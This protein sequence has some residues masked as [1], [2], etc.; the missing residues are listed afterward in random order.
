MLLPGLFALSTEKEDA[1]ARHFVQE[2]G[3]KYKI[4]E[5][6]D[7]VAALAQSL[8]AQRSIDVKTIES[9]QPLANN[10]PAG[11]VYISTALVQSATTAELAAILAHQIVHAT[12]RHG[13]I[14]GR[15]SIPLT[16]MGSSGGICMRGGDGRDSALLVPLSIKPRL[17]A[18]EAEADLL[19]A[20]Y[21]E[22]AGYEAVEVQPIFDR[23][24]RPTPAP[25]KTPTLMR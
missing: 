9:D 14:T 3:Q 13:Q 19:A 16:F 5:T 25:R 15:S 11:I 1:L 12:E 8:S 17:V 10:L 21:L 24:L 23:L 2:L 22:R 7:A 20:H 6:P 18:N 4:V